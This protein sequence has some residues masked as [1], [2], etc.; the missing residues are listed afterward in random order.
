[1]TNAND[2]LEAQAYMKQKE[3]QEENSNSEE[4][5]PFWELRGWVKFIQE[6]PTEDMPIRFLKNPAFY[7]QME[8]DPNTDLKQSDAHGF[9]N[10]PD[11]HHFYAMMNEETFYLVDARRNDLAR[12][13]TS[14]D[15][16]YLKDIIKP[17]NELEKETGGLLD[18]GGFQEGYCLKLTT[19]D[20][21]EY[22]FCTDDPNDKDDWYEHIL[23][24]VK[25]IQ[26]RVSGSAGIKSSDAMDLPDGFEFGIKHEAKKEKDVD[27]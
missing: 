21:I 18:L 3:R 8:M 14:I 22:T 20:D 15:F 9:L 1:M 27:G 7:H 2:K 12:T 4:E 17:S 11:D 16:K 5:G 23:K 6:K 24:Y 19:K 26:K 10:I 13:H 25:I